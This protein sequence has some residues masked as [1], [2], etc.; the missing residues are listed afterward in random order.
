MEDRDRLEPRIVTAGA[1]RVRLLRSC[2]R[3]V[4]ERGYEN[5][6][7]NEI[8]GRAGLTAG[9]I[10]DHFGSKEK[11]VVEAIIFELQ[12][13]KFETV[14]SMIRRTV[15]PENRERRQ[16]AIAVS[17]ASKSSTAIGEAVRE[18]VNQRSHDLARLLREN[19]EQ[20]LVRD[21]LD[22]ELLARVL[23]LLFVGVAAEESQGY[24]A[25]EP[26][27]LESL[28]LTMLKPVRTDQ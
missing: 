19:V 15:N 21:D 2:V 26:D 20:G 18:F 14:T 4:G 8:A 7:L 11:L 24:D 3:V 6:T 23:T 25:I 5:A 12:Q 17:M 22:I 9:A 13:P 16:F 27:E 28:F 1:T 10:Q